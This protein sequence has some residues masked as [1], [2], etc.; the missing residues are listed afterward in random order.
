MYVVQIIF[1]ITL[2]MT[3]TLKYMIT[4]NDY[5]CQQ[6]QQFKNSRAMF[7]ISVQK[8]QRI[9]QAGCRGINVITK[10]AQSIHGFQTK[11]SIRDIFYEFNK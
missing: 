8:K 4:L 10:R 1:S 9:I 5:R 7:L 11:I 3:V 6:S 2:L